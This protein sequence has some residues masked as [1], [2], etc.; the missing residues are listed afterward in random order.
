MMIAVRAMPFC[1]CRPPQMQKVG[2]LKKGI[3]SLQIGPNIR[4]AWTGIA[5]MSAMTSS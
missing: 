4:R 1:M 5:G 3:A 2:L